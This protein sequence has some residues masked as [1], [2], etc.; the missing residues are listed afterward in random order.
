L[1]SACFLDHKGRIVTD[2]L[3]WKRSEHEYYIDCPTP[4]SHHLFQHLKQHKLRKSQV[5][6]EK[7]KDDNSGDGQ[8]EAHSHAILGTLASGGAPPGFVSA[9]DPRH[10]SLGVRVLQLPPDASSAVPSADS[11]ALFS[12]MLAHSP[13]AEDLTGNYE[14]VR[15]LA[16]IATGTEIVGRTAIECNHEFLNSVSF[17][18]GCYLG[19]EL[20]ARV[21]HTGTVRKRL[22]PSCSR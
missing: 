22:S 3:L 13:F 12:Q 9:L 16:G 6:I 7:A 21:H 8:F 11:S 5:T 10:P 1:Y 4:T 20:T 2:S 18:K 19:Q 14:F 17:H 15:R